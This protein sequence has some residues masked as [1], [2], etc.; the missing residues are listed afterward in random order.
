MRKKHTKSHV[1]DSATVSSRV[2][3]GMALGSI[4]GVLRA[5]IVVENILFSASPL[6]IFIP[7]VFVKILPAT[8]EE[9]N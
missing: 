4:W 7:L 5:Q 1:D 8:L 3:L 6:V 9:S 2:C